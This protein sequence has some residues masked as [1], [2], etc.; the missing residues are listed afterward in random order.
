MTFEGTDIAGVWLIR[1]PV[2]ADARGWFQRTYCT[3]EFRAQGL[4]LPNV[5]SNL[6]FNRRRATLRGLHYQAPPHGEAKLVHCVQ[7]A[8]FDVVADIRSGSAS[9]GRWQAFELSPW[10]GWSLYVPPGV[11]HGFLTLEESSLVHYQMSAAYQ[12]DA[13]R[14]LRWDDA[15]F[16]I[17][18]PIEP[19]MISERDRVWPDF[20][21]THTALEEELHASRR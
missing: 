14:G 9:Y 20:P 5:Q 13:A 10:N 12:P 17:R 2:A 6:S 19:Q 18:W 15:S 8:I 11:A 1:A 21:L 7:G 16:A 4:E 3:Q